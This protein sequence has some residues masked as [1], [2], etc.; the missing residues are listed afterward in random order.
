MPLNEEWLTACALVPELVGE[1]LKAQAHLGCLQLESLSKLGVRIV[2]GGG[3]LA[4]KN[5]PV[6]GP[7]FFKRYVLPCYKLIAEKAKS[8][9]LKYVF[10]SDGN[11]WSITDDLFMEAGIEAYGEIDYDAGMRIPELQERYQHL[12]C[13]GNVSCALLRLGKPSEIKEVASQIVERCKERGRLILGSSNAVL[14]STP[15]ENYF[16]LLEA[17][18]S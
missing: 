8:L 10:R 5:G 14:P 9:G 12:T 6:Y 1:Y 4:D 18:K 15:P 16:A 2:W 11:L 3:D 7:N 13:W 17:A